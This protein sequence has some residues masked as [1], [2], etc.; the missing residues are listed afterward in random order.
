M[1]CYGCSSS[2]SQVQR[3]FLTK[4]EKIQMLRDYQKQ[5]EN[6]VKGIA[7]RIKQMDKESDD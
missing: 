4:G 1:D 2:C 3:G 7:E 6:E 5:L